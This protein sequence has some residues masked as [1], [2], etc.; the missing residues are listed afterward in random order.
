MLPDSLK[1]SQDLRLEKVS[2]RAINCLLC[3]SCKFPIPQIKVTKAQFL[4]DVEDT[5]M[6]RPHWDICTIDSSTSRIYKPVISH[7]ILRLRNWLH[8]GKDWVPRCVL[9]VMCSLL[10]TVWPRRGM[11]VTNVLFKN[12]NGTH[13]CHWASRSVR[14][15]ESN[16]L[17]YSAPIP[18]C[19]TWNHL[20]L[21]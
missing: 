6:S 21:S 20:V 8:M 11:Q 14:K 15:V 13:C 3:D 10:R 12:Q 19:N 18:C 2:R 17:P 16:C 5:Q 4:P 7:S 9:L 1:L